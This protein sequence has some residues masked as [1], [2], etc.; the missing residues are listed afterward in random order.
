MV[1]L[2]SSGPPVCPAP[3]SSERRERSVNGRDLVERRMTGKPKAHWKPSRP[4]TPLLYRY[5]ANSPERKLDGQSSGQAVNVLDGR[6][7][8]RRTSSPDDDQGT[9][10]LVG[11]MV[12]KVGTANAYMPAAPQLS[13]FRLFASAFI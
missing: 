10:M 13:S 3:S 7:M 11:V 2:S 8:R 5:I 9:D 12:D 4:Q 1:V 6:I